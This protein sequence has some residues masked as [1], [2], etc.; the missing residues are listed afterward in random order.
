MLN[1]LLFKPDNMVKS[2]ELI[3]DKDDS[4]YNFT[5]PNNI[6]KIMS[7]SDKTGDWWIENSANG[8]W[9]GG[10]HSWTPENTQ[11]E[12]I[13]DTEYGIINITSGKQYKLY[14][15]CSDIPELYVPPRIRWSNKIN[16]M[17]SDVSD[18]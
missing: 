17:P 10:T 8:K 13:E 16:Q 14:S 11:D 7:I 1:L 18:L 3:L 4:Y 6:K 9:W 12:V 5:V 2:G 15:C